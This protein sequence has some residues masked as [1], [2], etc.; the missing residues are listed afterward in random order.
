VVIHSR[1]ADTT[2]API[3]ISW[4]EAN[5]NHP[6][7]VIHCFNGSMETARKYLDAGFYISLGGF[8]TYPSSRKNYDVYRFIPMD[9]LLLETDCPFLP[10]QTHRGQRN[11]PSYLAQTTQT[12]AAIKE[13]PVE[14]LAYI[15]AKNTRQLFS[16]I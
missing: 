9:R 11:E 13:V 5:P 12:L 14:K 6:K 10:P 1:Q 15:T 7:G 2:I 16:L 4:A 3:L 8:V